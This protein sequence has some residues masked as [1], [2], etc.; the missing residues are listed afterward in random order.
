MPRSPLAAAGRDARGCLVVLL[1]V[2]VAVTPAAALDP[3]PEKP[4]WHGFDMLGVGIQHLGSSFISGSTFQE[5]GE[6]EI[7]S[8]SHG[9]ETV[10][11]VIP[12][13]RGE[14]G[15]RFAGSR[16]YLSA[17][18][19]LED[20]IRY[21][22]TASIRLIQGLGGEG[23]LGVELLA[24]LPVRIWEDPYVTGQEREPSDRELQRA[25][26][27]WSGIGPGLEIELTAGRT[28]IGTEHSGEFLGLTDAERRLLERDGLVR[29]VRVSYRIKLSE[30]HRLV[31]RASFQIQ[32]RD[33]E[34]MAHNV[35]GVEIDY[36]FHG[37]KATVT[38]TVY[39]E[40]SRYHEENP[41]YGKTADADGLGTS[42]MVLLPS[43]FPGKWSG[44]FRGAAYRDDSDIGF[45]D[46]RFASFALV[47]ARQW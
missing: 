39:A 17:G 19:S 42:F 4:G 2:L 44:G 43:W 40:S 3:L 25:R 20:L 41:I 21:D 45:F 35:A 13:L 24:G 33:G 27:T 30:R 14:I 32:D 12:V 47:S 28:E 37:E 38:A 1:P 34:A 7:D 23:L 10:R 11:N 31:P 15:Y 29:Q 26:L 5:F 18:H 22:F 6:A 36:F 16:T 9:P 8:L 46:A